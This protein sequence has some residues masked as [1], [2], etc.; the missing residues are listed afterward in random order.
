MPNNNERKPMPFVDYSLL[1]VETSRYLLTRNGSLLLSRECFSYQVFHFLA[2]NIHLASVPRFCAYS[3]RIELIYR[4]T[5]LCLGNMVDAHLTT[6]CH[7]GCSCLEA[8]LKASENSH[9]KG[10]DKSR[11]PNRSSLNILN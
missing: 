9:T 1:T 8:S 10:A 4:L 11:I 2:S 7:N 3:L 6:N 5:F